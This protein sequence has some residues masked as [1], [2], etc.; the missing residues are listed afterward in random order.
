MAVIKKSL[1][2]GADSHRNSIPGHWA[3]ESISMWSISHCLS[4]LKW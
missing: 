1:W 3:G 2:Q 4:L